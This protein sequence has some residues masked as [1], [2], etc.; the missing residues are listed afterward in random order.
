MIRRLTPLFWPRSEMPLAAEAREALADRPEDLAR[1]DEVLERALLAYPVREDN[2][3]FTFSAPLALLRY[4]VLELGR[5][6]VA[7]DNIEERDD[8]FFLEIEEARSE[9][10]NET[11]EAASVN[12]RALVQQ[13]KGETRLGQ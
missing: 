6:L 7:R 1:F 3:F 12:Y 11:V 10:L 8:I 5:R 13:R 2:E 4:T 9:M